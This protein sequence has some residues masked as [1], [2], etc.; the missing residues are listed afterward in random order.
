MFNL[1]WLIPVFPLLAFALI[2][3][4]THDDKR[5]STYMA[6]GGIGL[7]WI[8]SW[9][10]VLR[11]HCG[12]ARLAEH[13]SRCRSS[14]IPT[15]D[16]HAAAGLHGGSAD[17]GHAVHGAVRLPDDLHLLQGLHGLGHGGV[18]QRYS[19]FFAYIS[20]FACGMLGLVVSDNLL[21]LFIFWEFMGL[22]S[23]L[24]IGFWFEKRYAD[25]KRITPKQAGLKAFIT[26]RVGDVSCSSACCYLYVA[27]RHAD[28]LRDLLRG[29]P[30]AS[31]GRRRSPCRCSARC[32]WPR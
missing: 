24:L 18:D 20:L 29:Q 25:P 3:L 14:S 13:P 2:I 22:C 12:T 32:R 23:Y 16:D 10:V 7:S 28:L 11:G 8:V 19:R 21:I 5:L 1:I 30:G 4:F 26:T 6:W 9:A 17:G 15:G 27:D 31:G